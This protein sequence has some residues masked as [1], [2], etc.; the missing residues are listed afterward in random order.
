M[1][2]RVLVS[3]VLFKAPTK[4]ISKNGKP[5]VFSSIREGNGD[6]AR[7]WKVF[8]FSVSAIEEIECLKEGEAISVC[9]AFEVKIY[10]PEGKEPRVDLTLTAD[11]VLSARPRPK[12]PKKTAPA[13][14]APDRREAPEFDDALPERWR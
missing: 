6:S 5:Y 11:A 10:T 3:G 8:V 9:G 2:A 7:W 4:K 14:A 12:E 1:T 13:R